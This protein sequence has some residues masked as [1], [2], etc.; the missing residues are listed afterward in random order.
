MNVNKPGTPFLIIAGTIILLGGLSL[1]PWGELTNNR[2]KNFNLI[3]DLCPNQQSQ[4]VTTDETIDPELAAAL[5]KDGATSGAAV[6]DSANI[7]ID[8]SADGY[9]LYELVNP[10]PVAKSRDADSTVIIEDYTI[11]GQGLKNL[12]NALKNRNKKVVRIAMIGD[13]YIEGDILTMDLRE[14]LQNIYGGSGVGYMPAHSDLTGFRT[15]VSQSCSGW[16]KHD[17]RKN[18]REEM[19]TLPGEYCTAAGPAKTTYKGVDRK[20]YLN[21][22]NT[23]TVLAKAPSGG[24]ITL[25]TDSSSQTLQIP[26][27]GKVHSLTINENTA[28]ANLTATAGV[29]VFGVYMNDN[30]GITVDNMSLRGNSGITHRAL[31][32]DLAHQMRPDVDYD[33]IIVEY[34]MNALNSKQ[35]NYSGYQK[36]MKQTISRLKDC[37]PNA[38]ILFMGIG[39]RGQKLAGAF[40]SIPTSQHMTDAQRDAARSTG[41]LFW[42]ARQAMGGDGAAVRWRE[43]G[44]VNPDYIHLNHKGGKRFSDLLFKAIQRNLNNTNTKKTV[45]KKVK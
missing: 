2:F 26:A 7:F 31:A 41:V 13:S 23:T 16:Q 9:S 1:L 24:S 45:Q 10:R 29:E 6:V 11:E 36:L 4:E 28:S 39:D 34:G 33:L 44:L 18:M 5:G 35:S 19:K 12:R 40:K 14:S 8:N 22:W 38:D 21:R 25:S 27:D 3:A 20:P 42:D 43:E 15:T 17:I 37:Y 30:K 32:V